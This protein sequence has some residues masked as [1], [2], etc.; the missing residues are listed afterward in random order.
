MW[1]WGRS[2]DAS[3]LGS[4]RP[5][6]AASRGRGG[7]PGGRAAQ[8][9][10][11]RGRQRVAPESVISQ[12]RLMLIY[13]GRDIETHL[14]QVPGKTSK[15]GILRFPEESSPQIEHLWRTLGQMV[16]SGVSAEKLLKAPTT[17]AK[18]SPRS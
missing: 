15:R 14:S 11:R 5:T 12:T 10:V 2:A 17:W 6:S 3:P 8:R 1:I 9:K 18:Q 13:L 7:S 16:P 4:A